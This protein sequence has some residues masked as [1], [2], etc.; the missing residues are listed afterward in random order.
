VSELSSSERALLETA[1]EDWGP[2]ECAPVPSAS[3]IEKR[4]ADKP[5]LAVPMASLA[6]SESKVGPGRLFGITAAAIGICAVALVGFV[7]VMR[8]ESA[9]EPA[10][11]TPAIT[12]VAVPALQPAETSASA[13]PSVA[14]DTLPDAPAHAGAPKKS[15][16]ARRPPE[17][18]APEES[19]PRDVLGEEIALIRAAQGHLRAG[20]PDRALGSLS[21]HASRFPRGVLRDERMALQVL[22]LC[23]RGDADAARAVKSELEQSSPSSS[24]LQRLAS[25][26][27]R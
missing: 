8:T 11:A 16:E 7:G 4:L 17:R 13:V 10:A 27:A 15:R 26:C 1:R 5:W 3:A 9:P 2:S 19:A 25:S 22:A 18:A 24:H 6:S 14:I 21:T 12:T 20:A 23:E